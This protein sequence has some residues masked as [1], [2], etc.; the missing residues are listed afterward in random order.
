MISSKA[1]DQISKIE[2]LNSVC[3]SISESKKSV[4]PTQ[5][6]EDFTYTKAMIDDMKKFKT[7]K[8]SKRWVMYP[9]GTGGETWLRWWTSNDTSN[10]VKPKGISVLKDSLFCTKVMPKQPKDIEDYFK[11]IISNKGV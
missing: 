1:D 4:Q 7:R 3:L 8:W 5:P 11:K 2:S 6:K 10:H 9:C